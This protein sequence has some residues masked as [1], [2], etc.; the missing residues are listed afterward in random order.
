MNKP[1]RKTERQVKTKR[2]ENVNY[3]DFI[4]LIYNIVL[5][6]WQHGNKIQE[7]K[8]EKRHE[9][10]THTYSEKDMVP[11]RKNLKLFPLSEW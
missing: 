5:K 2:K 8:L 3:G 6:T 10:E 11:K 4:F 7:E 1:E 9:Q